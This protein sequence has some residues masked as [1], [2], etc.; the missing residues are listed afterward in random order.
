[1]TSF[2]RL[3]IFA[4][5]ATLVLASVGG[6]VRATESGLGCPDWPTCHGR[7]V[8]PSESHSLI[9]FSHRLIAA[10]VII[11]CIAL[12]TIAW[13]KYREHRG[14]LGPALASVV[15]VFAQAALG[16]VVVA[17]DLDAESVVAHLLV[18]MSLL[19]VL[20]ALVTNI[21][22]LE[23]P[24]TATGL[25]DHRFA[26]SALYVAGATLALMLL[27]SYV[28]GRNAGLAFPDWPLFDGRVV[29][30]HGGLLPSLHAAHRVAAAIVGAGVIWLAAYARKTGQHPAIVRL[31]TFSTA[32]FAVQVLLGAGNIWTELGVATRTAHLA[33]GAVIWS[34]LFAAAYAARR[35]PVNTTAVE[36]PVTPPGT[37]LVTRP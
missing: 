8:P 29:P 28:S 25:Q 17:L 14:I 24:P 10:V 3:A 26:R 23:N 5:G 7:V 15:I 13:R 32:G 16:A 35:L 4:T 12:A 30:A 34:L 6:F 31:T 18:A 33:T 11:S 36:V 27:G 19:A 22:L 2:R 20:I 1:M 9:E 37:V 21:V